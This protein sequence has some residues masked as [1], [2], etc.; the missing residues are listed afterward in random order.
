[1]PDASAP[2]SFVPLEIRPSLAL[3]LSP[4]LWGALVAGVLIAGALLFRALLAHAA[5]DAPD[6]PADIG[7]ATRVALVASLSVGY[8]LG[9][10][11]WGS[12]SQ[13]RDFAELGLRPE[14][15]D[16]ESGSLHAVSRDQ[17]RRSRL[18]G[19]SG[20]AFFFAIVELPG[21]FAGAVS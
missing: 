3:R 9:V 1:M 11:R 20:V 14:G 21:A 12:A 5:L 18:A 15:G 8:T 4:L 17:L 13:F 10:W 2:R 16:P 6:S 19:A 7:F